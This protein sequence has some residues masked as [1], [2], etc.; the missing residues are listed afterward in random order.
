MIKDILPFRITIEEVDLCD[1]VIVFGNIVVAVGQKGTVL[2]PSVKEQVC[3]CA[4]IDYNFFRHKSLDALE[5][6]LRC[7]I[8][9]GICEKVVRLITD[10]IGIGIQ[11]LLNPFRL[12]LLPVFDLLI[13]PDTDKAG[14]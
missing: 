8:E 9:V 2:F 13:G 11:P 12:S 5:G 6:K 7:G 1:V 4:H 14:V 3:S 10:D